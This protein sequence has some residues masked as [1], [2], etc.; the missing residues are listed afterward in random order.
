VKKVVVSF[1]AS[2]FTVGGSERVLSHLITRLPRDR[3]RVNLYFLREAGRVGR[4]LF[5][6]GVG[7]AER[8]QRHR[9]DP[10]AAVRLCRHLRH[11]PPDLLFV[12][13]HHNAMLW[14]RVAALLAPVPRVVLASHA[15]GL[16][17]K[18]RN[19]RVT[20]RWLMEFTD[21][22]V[23]LSRAHARY[24]VETEGVAPGCVTIIENGIPL[25]EYAG[26][27]AVGEARAGLEREL[28]LGPQDRVV[29]MVAALRPE[30]AHEVFLEAARLLVVSHRDL[31]FLIVGDGPRRAELE[32][33]CTRLDLDPHVRFLG[34]RS[35]VARLLHVARVLAL[36]SHP[37]V[38]TLPLSVLE[39]MA[40]GVPVVATRVGSLPEVIDSGR[41]G[42]LIDPG[43][44][45]ALAS[46]IESLV[47]DPV[48]S[49]EMAAAAREVVV[50]RFSVDRMVDGYA[51]LFQSLAE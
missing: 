46:A 34:V 13:D 36:P 32:L 3:Y 29:I 22:V 11:D 15:T 35:D 26:D 23:A 1:V 20:D 18:R 16:F 9:F 44:P 5:D 40:A 51:A 28:A 47:D 24:L 2:T 27:D 17:G 31:K 10:V 6:A 4:E 30:K 39:A 48:R 37:A 42:L 45:R 38:E 14:G 8:L 43:D 49:R 19:F 21:R 50:S 7:G 33:L 41:T 25:D 12:L